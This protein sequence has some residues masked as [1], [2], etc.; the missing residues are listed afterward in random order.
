MT[1]TTAERHHS[2][3]GVNADLPLPGRARRS[4]SVSVSYSSTPCHHPATYTRQL[5]PRPTLRQ[6]PAPHHF[7]PTCH[8][9]RGDCGVSSAP[10][11]N[12]AR[13]GI[14]S[15]GVLTY[16]SDSPP[17]PRSDSRSQ[18]RL[19]VA[20]LSESD[21]T[22]VQRI[23]AM[24]V[25]LWWS[26]PRSAQMWVRKV[27]RLLMLQNRCSLGECEWHSRGH[28]QPLLATYNPG[29]LRYLS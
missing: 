22:P 24:C 25:D 18:Q 26:T 27:A 9:G 29:E 14:L 2:V 23:S 6:T 15:A 3:V 28:E 10:N 12:T 13:P 11:T 5:T 17:P 19:A 7:Q 20:V 16:W 8:P 21:I 1:G 4:T